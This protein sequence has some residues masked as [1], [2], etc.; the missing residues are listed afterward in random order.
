MV[1]PTL[2]AI[3]DIF[4]NAAFIAQAGDVA[5]VLRDLC[6]N[7]DQAKIRVQSAKDCHLVG[8]NLNKKPPLRADR[9]PLNSLPYSLGLSNAWSVSASSRA[10][11][12]TR[13]ALPTP[14]V[15]IG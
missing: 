8:S 1:L 3:L 10:V 4:E 2:A 6:F 9:W 14:P 7:M 13:L 15:F 5:E 12:F 11:F